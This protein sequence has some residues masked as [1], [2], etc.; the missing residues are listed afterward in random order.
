[1]VEGVLHRL[2][3]GR[4]PV[5]LLVAWL[6][7]CALEASSPTDAYRASG[8]AIQA[9]YEAALPQLPLDKQ[10]HYAQRLYRISGEPRYL[11][12]LEAHGRRLL[13]QLE[14]DIAGLERPGFAAARARQIVA[15]YPQRTAKQRARQ[16]MLAEWGEIAF[17]RQLLFRLVQA[18]YYGLLEA[19]PDHQ[20]ALDYLGSLA[21]QRFLTDPEVVRLYTAQVANQAWFLHQLEVVDLRPAVREAFLSVFPAQSVADLEQADYRNRLYGMTHIVIADSRYYQRWVPAERHAWILEALAAEIERILDQ[22][23]EDIQAEVALVFLL[24]GNEGHPVVARIRQRLA[25]AV[26][27]R[28]GIIPS[29][30]GEIDLARGEHRNVLALMVLTWPGRLHPGPDLS[31]GVRSGAAALRRACPSLD[32]RAGP[33]HLRCQ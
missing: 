4:W 21:W 22:A 14:R 5:L 32:E 11:P 27:P 24:T 28:A 3:P 15:D 12:P 19:I 29:P 2:S 1:M 20:R 9:V 26:D 6:A 16:V 18:D 30:R 25:E 33:L 7:G 8:Q 17:A 10:R 23:T 31:A 13:V